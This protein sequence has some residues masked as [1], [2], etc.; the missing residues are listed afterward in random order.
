MLLALLLAAP[1]RAL[2]NAAI[3]RFQQVDDEGALTH[4]LPRETTDVR[5][6]AE[7]VV[8]VPFWDAAA[9]RAQVLVHTWYDLVSARPQPGL[10]VGF[11]EVKGA[12]RSSDSDLTW[13]NRTVRLDLPT[14]GRFSA[15]ADGQPLP[16][17]EHP[18][19]GRYRRWFTFPVT[20][21]AGRPVRLHTVYVSRIGR[22]QRFEY[23]L[24]GSGLRSQTF[25]TDHF[26]DYVLHT[27]G[28]WSGPIG[29]GEVV[30]FAEGRPHVL[31]R[32][33]RL[34][35]TRADDLTVRL[36]L[37][38]REPRREFDRKN[39]Q[40]LSWVDTLRLVHA[41]SEQP[42]SQVEGLSALAVDGDAGTAWIS[43]PG[44]GVGAWL[45]VPAD[46]ERHLESI[47]VLGLGRADV[48]RP[49]RIELRCVHRHREREVSRP[50]ATVALPDTVGPHRLPARSTRG[51][52]ALR[53]NVL[54]VHGR[55]SSP[56]AI[57]EVDQRYRTAPSGP[58][59]GVKLM[60]CCFP[61]A[62]RREPPIAGLRAA[63]AKLPPAQLGLGHEIARVSDVRW[64]P[65]GTVVHYLQWLEDEQHAPGAALLGHLVEV[66][67]GRLL[68]RYRVDQVGTL[69][70]PERT[71]WA[72]AL[73]FVEGD[74]RVR[75]AGL[76]PALAQRL[77][78]R[79]VPAA[80]ALDLRPDLPPTVGRLRVSPQSTGF[81]WWYEPNRHARLPTAAT[82]ALDLVATGA[83]SER[84]SLTRRGPPLDPGLALKHELTRE[85]RR[86]RVI[87]ALE[88]EQRPENKPGPLEVARI[89]PTVHA[90][91][92]EVRLHWEP[93]GRAVLVTW[94]SA[95]ALGSLLP[96]AIVTAEM[97]RPRPWRRLEYGRAQVEVTV[98]PLVS[99]PR[100]RD[101]AAA[102]GAS[103]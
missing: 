91:T 35:P 60:P 102:T 43:A 85:A 13:E 61:A 53:L 72:T 99:A 30:V 101:G 57:A 14:I 25:L 33:T 83:R 23:Q 48:S 65:D 41:S 29:Q 36:G 84:R 47:T 79:G 12:Y 26:I 5:M 70:E 89:F 3:V 74:R 86:Q 54:A 98:H 8:L 81:T 21:P 11:P 95:R 88:D 39:Q 4:V 103:R 28:L 6:A 92:G 59:W 58:P 77:A 93:R 44:R 27:G 82:G 17:R 15:F 20:L 31:R 7:R 22:A 37:G 97:A 55:A 96:E 75:Q 51:C 49:A 90:F 76:V 1:D 16:V 34:K 50:L 68:V 94:R 40:D 32:F 66:A 63:I 45:Q 10:P 80:T 38:R 18:G 62:V 100:P 67:T 56:V 24:G 69:R 9:R 2:A 52:A 71:H 42:G 73:P 19:V 46:P 78:P 64:S 87:K